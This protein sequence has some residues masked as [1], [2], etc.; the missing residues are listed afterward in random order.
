MIPVHMRVDKNIY[1]VSVCK[2][3]R[4]RSCEDGREA[5]ICLVS[6]QKSESMSGWLHS[7]VAIVFVPFSKHGKLFSFYANDVFC[8]KRFSREGG[9]PTYMQPYA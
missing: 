1:D 9:L 5:C 3:S 7:I 4:S 8:S 6:C 2:S